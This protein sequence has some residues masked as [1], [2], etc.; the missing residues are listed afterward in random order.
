MAVYTLEID[1]SSTA[2]E[3]TETSVSVNVTESVATVEVSNAGVQGI[4]GIQGPKGDP[5]VLT[6]G[7]VSATESGG[8]PVVTI[9]G[10]A[11]EQVVNFVLPRGIQGI[12]GEVGPTGP[13]GPQGETGPIGATGATGINWQGA[14]DA[15]T[16]YVDNDAVYYNGTSWFASGDPTVG[17]TPSLDSANWF[18]LAIQGATGATGAT[19]PQG[20]TGPQGPQGIQGIQGIQGPT[21]ATGATGPKGDKGDTGEQGIQGIQGETGATGATGA[22][23]PQGPQGIQGDTGPQGIQGETGPQGIQGIQGIQGEPGVVTANSPVIYN[24][25]TQ[26]VGIDQTLISIQPSQVAG[27]AVTNAVLANQ[28]ITVNG[29]AISLGGS[30]TVYAVLA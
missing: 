25:E 11:P 27:T 14:W 6:V 23:G 20:E 4:Q 29:T 26:A 10:T 1:K 15:E 7:E 16:D 9:T 24:A 13:Q 2:L 28:T 21:G 17:E 3:I 22:T 19:G 12:Q 30:V 18:P 5:N 8:T